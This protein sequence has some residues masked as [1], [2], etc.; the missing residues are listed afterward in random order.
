MDQ[1]S[2]ARSF[3]LVFA[4]LPLGRVLA[5]NPH[6]RERHREV[7]FLSLLLGAATAAPPRCASG[8]IEFIGVGFPF[9]LL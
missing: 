2:K 6:A 8:P 1:H 7:C 4:K 3:V 9:R 5:G